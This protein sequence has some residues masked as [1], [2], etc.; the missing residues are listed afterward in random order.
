MTPEKTQ[1]ELSMSISC[2][3]KISTWFKAATCSLPRIP[4]QVQLRDQILL[5]FLN[6][7]TLSTKWR[8]QKK[9]STHKSSLSKF[10]AQYKLWTVRF[11]KVPHVLDPQS[12]HA[13]LSPCTVWTDA[14]HSYMSSLI[15][16]VWQNP[17]HMQIKPFPN[18]S[19]A[20]RPP[21]QGY[22]EFA[23]PGEVSQKILWLHI[24]KKKTPI[25][26]STKQVH[27]PV[28]ETALNILHMHLLAPETALNILHA[29]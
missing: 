12:F 26:G 17:K 2:T 11:N 6:F 24:L 19:V 4:A 20:E 21:I 28:P 23:K 10:T 16:Q 8:E 13:I 14:D 29:A 3:L 22:P 15:Q 18:R 27:L 5:N 1:K 25:G 7:T 9:H